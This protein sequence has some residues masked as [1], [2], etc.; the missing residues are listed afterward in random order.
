[1]FPM[2]HLF[3]QNPGVRRHWQVQRYRML[4]GGNIRC[5]TCKPSVV[6]DQ[7]PRPRG[8][9]RPTTPAR[10]FIV[11][12]LRKSGKGV[13]FSDVCSKNLKLAEKPTEISRPDSRFSCTP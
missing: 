2:P 7:H 8:I 13:E 4:H 10:D 6:L 5:E 3:I 11:K 12:T 1:A 9:V